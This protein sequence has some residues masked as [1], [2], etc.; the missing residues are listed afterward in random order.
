MHV[1]FKR[2]KITSLPI[3]RIESENMLPEPHRLGE[4][5]V[6]CQFCGARMWAE[7]AMK[8]GRGPI[9]ARFNLC[10]GG[11][12]KVTGITPLREPPPPLNQLYAGRFVLHPHPDAEHFLENI[13]AYNCAF[14]MASSTAH[15]DSRNDQI[16]AGP[17]PMQ[18]KINGEV[19][20]R[21]GGMLASGEPRCAQLYIMTPDMAAVARFA[22]YQSRRPEGQR[23]ALTLP[24]P[25]RQPLIQSIETTLRTHNRYVTEYISSKE[26]EEQAV[27]R[28]D[29]I[30]D[31]CMTISETGEAHRGVHVCDELGAFVPNSDVSDSVQ[32]RTI[33]LR[34]RDQTLRKI[35]NLNAAY[36]PL[37]YP[38]LFP[39]GEPGWS[40]MMRLH[41]GVSNL[42]YTRYRLHYRPE[43]P[44]RESPHLLQVNLTIQA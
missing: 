10:C 19:H 20:H 9:Q 28:G 31:V 18:W 39:Y 2:L 36:H 35:S 16:P 40:P 22:Y 17:G 21:V 24:V 25:L 43:G 38:L 44:H 27:V 7:E 6:S 26:V 42:A 23:G 1:Q 29:R 12:G 34:R 8:S 33:Y 30:P 37:H 41:Q 11:K 32:G 3:F 5:N 14:Q 13:R 4:Q 15:L